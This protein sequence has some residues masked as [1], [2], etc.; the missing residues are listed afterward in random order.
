MDKTALR[1]L[2]GGG[3]KT[4]S[5]RPTVAKTRLDEEIIEDAESR[6]E[7]FTEEADRWH[8]DRQE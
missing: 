1:L 4:D 3:E 2:P 7:Q 6:H 8:D 5:P